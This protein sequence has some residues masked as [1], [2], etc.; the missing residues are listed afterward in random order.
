M[1]LWLDGLQEPLVIDGEHVCSLVIENPTFMLNVLRD[2]HDQC[3]GESGKA[4][5]SYKNEILAIDRGVELMTDFVTF[6][7]NKKSL[8]T[9]IFHV[10]ENVAND[11]VY[12]HRTQK[13]LADMECY[14]NDLSMEQDVE[15]AYDKLS[16]NNLL[17]SVGMRVV[18]DYN[19]LV[20]R[21]LAYMDLVRRFDRE[22][23][24]LLV[25]LRSFVSV[26][27]TNLFM[28]TVAAHGFRVLL[29]DNQTYPVLAWE[30]RRIID[31]DLCELQ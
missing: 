25:N 29:I 30:K 21:L 16:L 1:K 6:D 28:K 9:K 19:K 3:Q 2:I 24:F 15:L 12:Y 31:I 14:F 13:L 5:L 7:G 11:E 23:L 18:I 27:D 20:E 8:L 17:K 4:V 22:K 10:L 26:E